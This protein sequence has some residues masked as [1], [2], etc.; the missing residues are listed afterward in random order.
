MTGERCG[1]TRTG[2]SQP[3]RVAPIG[4]IEAQRATDSGLTSLVDRHGGRFSLVSARF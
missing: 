1:F 3:S 2:R 4:W